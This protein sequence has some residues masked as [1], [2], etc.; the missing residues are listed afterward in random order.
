MFL[1][2]YT[3]HAAVVCRP[4]PSLSPW[5]S[6]SH[7]P[8]ARIPRADSCITRQ[9]GAARERT[10]TRITVSLS[11]LGRGRGGNAHNESL[12]H[13]QERGPVPA[14]GDDAG[15]HGEQAEGEEVLRDGRRVAFR[16]V[17][18]VQLPACPTYTNIPQTALLSVGVFSALLR[19][20][21]TPQRD[22]VRSSRRC[23]SKDGFLYLAGSRAGQGGRPSL[24]PRPQ[25]PPSSWRTAG[26]AHVPDPN[27]NQDTSPHRAWSLRSSAVT[28]ACACRVYE[29]RQR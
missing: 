5:W 22:T 2:P 18:P 9:T 28:G 13:L 24:G 27:P 19:K 25:R 14:L 12:G 26:I 20:G 16:V 29:R 3:H 8:F 21:S 11:G 1:A 6:H 7:F 15:A 17:R 10:A 4:H 23:R